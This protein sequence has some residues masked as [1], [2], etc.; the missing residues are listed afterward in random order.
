MDDGACLWSSLTK[1]S[2]KNPI[3]RATTFAGAHFAGAL[4]A[5]AGCAP[6]ICRNNVH[7]QF[8]FCYLQVHSEHLQFAP[9]F[10]DILLH[11]FSGNFTNR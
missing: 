1:L 10:T 4:F 3:A 5:G 11:L 9:L 2:P 6:A 8:V 7:L